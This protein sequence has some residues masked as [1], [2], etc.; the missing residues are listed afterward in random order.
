MGDKLL[1]ILSEMSGWEESVTLFTGLTD[2]VLPA[3]AADDAADR[4]WVGDVFSNLAGNENY[5]FNYVPE[6]GSLAVVHV[7]EPATTSLGLAALVA[8]AARRRRK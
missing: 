3:V 5:Y 8:L 1:G 6:V 7:P 4:L 2:L